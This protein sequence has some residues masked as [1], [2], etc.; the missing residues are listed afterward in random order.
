MVSV[1]R[2]LSTI[3]EL[4]K[5]QN[6]LFRQGDYINKGY[7]PEKTVLGSGPGEEIFYTLETGPNDDR[8]I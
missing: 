7:K 2:K 1:S 4:R 8:G 3:E 5:D 6:R